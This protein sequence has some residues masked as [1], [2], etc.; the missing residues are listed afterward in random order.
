MPRLRRSKLD[1]PGY[2]R[3]RCGKGFVLLDPAG[4]RVEDAAVVERIQGLV[5]PPA[6]KDVWISS[7]PNGHIQAVGTDAAGR[8]QYRYH[9]A[10]RLRRDAQK[11][12]RMITFAQA[13]PAVRDATAVHLAH[14]DLDR[15]RVLACCIRLLDRGFF[16]IGGEAYAETNDSYGLAT[17]RKDHV[18]LE[19]NHRVVFEY[20]A[21]SGKERLQSIVDPDVFAVV[22]AL[23]GRRTGGGELFAY[24]EARQWRD[25]RSSDI[26]LYLKELAG[27]DYSAKVFRTWHATVLAAVALAVSSQAL[28]TKTARQRAITRATA[29][30][31]HYLGNTPA[32]ARRSYIDPRVI[33]RFSSGVT[34]SV[35]TMLVDDA[36]GGDTH[37]QMALEHAVVDLL[38]GDLDSPV[39]ERAS[40]RDGAV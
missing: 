27:G 26:N 25:V 10:W 6:W 20:T 7:H 29:E 16:R 13:L 33:D 30:V 34:I 4:Q 1:E 19:P 14:P 31:A 5:I 35:A 37:M 11:F 22:R 8:K 15:E 2:T 23:R 12:D 36:F 17:M 18:S 32:V 3:R 40:Q 21:K 28:R 39:V 24:R 38:R 9:D